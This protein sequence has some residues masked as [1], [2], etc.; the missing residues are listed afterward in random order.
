MFTHSCV[1]GSTASGSLPSL[2]CGDPIGTGA[3]YSA[4][5]S[6]V[7]RTSSMPI[8][9]RKNVGTSVVTLTRSRLGLGSWVTATV[10]FRG[11]PTG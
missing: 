5:A 7:M 4:T 10:V 9:P 11:P 6:R 1:P 8:S 3:T 2:F